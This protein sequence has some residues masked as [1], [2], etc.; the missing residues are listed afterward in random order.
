MTL[1][2][3]Y[4]EVLKKLTVLASEESA[5]A[6]DRLSVKTKYEQV[7][8]E[9]SRRNL[10][11]WFDDEDVPDWIADSFATMVASRLANEFAVPDSTRL[12][13]KADAVTAEAVLIGD[14]QRRGDYNHPET[15]YF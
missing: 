15:E 3:F 11:N 10:V 6:S 2:D 13:L 7:H 1:E 14:G 5:T 12:E 8:A 9:Y 4:E